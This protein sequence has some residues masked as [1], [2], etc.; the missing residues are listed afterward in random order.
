LILFSSS[1]CS[2]KKKDKDTTTTSDKVMEGKSVEI[3]NALFDENPVQQGPVTG[4]V[5]TDFYSS[6]CHFLIRILD[7]ENEKKEL[8]LQTVYFPVA[9]DSSYLVNGLKMKF[10]YIPSKA[11]SGACTRGMPIVLSDIEVIERP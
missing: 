3:D 10:T 9:L 4:E 2:D 5:T 8:L 11:F 1:K 7:G 6:G